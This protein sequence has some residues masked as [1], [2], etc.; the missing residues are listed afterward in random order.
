MVTKREVRAHEFEL[1]RK[2]M[3]SMTT[4]ELVDGVRKSSFRGGL[5]TAAKEVL[6]ERGVTVGPTPDE[7]E[8]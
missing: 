3:Q 1:H 2:S 7:A 4:D 5:M 8:A 6:R